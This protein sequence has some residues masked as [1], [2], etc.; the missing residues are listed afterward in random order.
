MFIMRLPLLSLILFSSLTFAQ[1]VPQLEAALKKNP[2]D[3]KARERLAGIHAAKN[4]HDKTIELLNPYTDQLK[5]SGFL[6]LANSYAK[7]KDF[8]NE[9]RTLNFLVA[10]D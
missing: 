5:D 9:V 6:L 10:K 8:T 7:K 1:S 4:E 3:M 2:D